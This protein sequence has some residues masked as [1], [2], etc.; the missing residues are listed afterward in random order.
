MQ[1]MMYTFKIFLS[2]F[3][4]PPPTPTPGFFFLTG[5]SCNQV[6]SGALC[7]DQAEIELTEIHRALL[8]KC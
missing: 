2:E 8:F 7:I 3:L 1:V 6:W 4:P 5:F